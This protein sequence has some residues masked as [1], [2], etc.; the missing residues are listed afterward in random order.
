ML[1]SEFVFG[2]IFERPR[3]A[4]EHFSQALLS[5]A[6][7]LAAADFST[8]CSWEALDLPPPLKRSTIVHLG[9]LTPGYQ[10]LKE[11]L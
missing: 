1:N 9:R 5:Y 3:E 4:S 10:Y 7:A 11:H 6:P 2:R 8:N